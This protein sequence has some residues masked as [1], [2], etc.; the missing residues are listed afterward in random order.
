MGVPGR[1]AHLLRCRLLRSGWKHHVI[2]DR[3]GEGGRGRGREE[4]GEFKG[5]GLVVEEKGRSG[6]G[7][8]V[9]L[10]EM[11]VGEARNGIGKT[12]MAEVT[13]ATM[14]PS[15]IIPDVI[16]L[17]HVNPYIDPSWT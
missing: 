12:V 4:E 10:M 17:I 11:V 7:R 6:T 15:N 16:I 9:G 5:V 3:K 14:L 13:M 2:S 1:H 8:P